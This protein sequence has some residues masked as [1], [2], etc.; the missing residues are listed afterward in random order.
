MYSDTSITYGSPGDKLRP[1]P[2]FEVGASKPHENLVEDARQWLVAGRDAQ[3]V[4]LIYIQ[5][6]REAL[7]AHRKT[8]RLS[9]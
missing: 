3:L 4:V 8:K 6:D 5:E 1:T 2:I 9:G 7:G